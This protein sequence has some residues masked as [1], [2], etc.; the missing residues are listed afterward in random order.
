MHSLHFFNYDVVFNPNG[1][2]RFFHRVNHTPTGFAAIWITQLGKI[3]IKQKPTELFMSRQEKY[4]FFNVWR[5]HRIYGGSWHFSECS[6]KWMGKCTLVP[7]SLNDWVWLNSQS[8]PCSTTKWN[9]GQCILGYGHGFRGHFVKPNTT[10]LCISRQNK[11][12][13]LRR[14]FKY[15]MCIPAT[16][17][18]R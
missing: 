7:K 6:L 13:I 11:S 15:G 10:V 4:R 9:L 16:Y 12:V 18:K 8:E 5:I 3:S 1:Y 2:V 17:V 14:I